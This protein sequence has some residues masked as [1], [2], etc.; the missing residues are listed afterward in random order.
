MKVAIITGGETA[1]RDISIRSAQNAARSLDVAECDVFVFPEE[2]KRFLGEVKMYDLVIPVI[3]GLGGE[4][5]VLQAELD[6]L[7]IPYLFSRAETHAL[8][9]DK[10]HTKEFVAPLEILT[11]G[12]ADVPPVFVKPRFGGSSFASKFCNTEDEV[13]ELVMAHPEIEFIKE[14]PLKGREFTVGVIE[15]QGN[16]IALP[17]TEIIPRG[18]FFDFENKYDPSKLALEVCPAEIEESLS[19]ELKRQAL[20]VHQS[21]G[22]RHVSRSDFIIT[23]DGTIY[24]LEINTIPGMTDTSL[25]PKMLEVQG[26]SLSGLFR[27]WIDVV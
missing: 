1:E 12:I 10:K 22:V 25:L 8:A 16:L 26:L 27:E 2:R 18:E 11:A 20:L 4:D 17:V 9:I 13:R 15:H 5:G 3:H 24:F 7:G 6:A 21:F 23:P 14:K 19:L